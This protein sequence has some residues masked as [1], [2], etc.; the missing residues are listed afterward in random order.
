MCVNFGS[1][2]FRELTVST[3]AHFSFLVIL[4][5]YRKIFHDMAAR[6][7]LPGTTA[8]TTISWVDVILAKLG[9]AVV[10]IASGFEVT[11]AEPPISKILKQQR[12]EDSL[13]AAAQLPRTLLSF[14]FEM[15][16]NLRRE[17]ASGA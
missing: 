16:L 3:T 14:P 5:D 2:L 7:L 15:Y 6:A 17:M 1:P 10:A 13:R 9:D 4:F 11:S 8:S 12:D